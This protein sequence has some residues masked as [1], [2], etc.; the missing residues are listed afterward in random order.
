MPGPLQ[1]G[2]VG[3]TVFNLLAI[4]ILLFYAYH[5]VE[6]RRASDTRVKRT[7]R[8]RAT[9]SL[10]GFCFYAVLVAA[11]GPSGTWV[12]PIGWAVN[13]YFRRVAEGLVTTGTTESGGSTLLAGIKVLG[14]I[15]YVVLFSVLTVSN[16]VVKRIW[17]GVS[18]RI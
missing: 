1:A 10:M 2:G 3:P 18:D 15:T 6:Y 12:E 16:G 4:A 13:S 7:A 17:N 5:H 9:A 14:L 11:Y 8:Q